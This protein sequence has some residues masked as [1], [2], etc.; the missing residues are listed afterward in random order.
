M[1]RSTG[2]LTFIRSKPCEMCRTSE[3]VIAHH[4]PMRM[5]GTGIKAPDSLTVPLCTY[6]HGLRHQL[7]S[8]SFWQRHDMQRIIIGHL[9]EYLEKLEGKN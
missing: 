4:E 6:C 5:G 9:T 8:K 1:Y 3:N 2:Y 7:G